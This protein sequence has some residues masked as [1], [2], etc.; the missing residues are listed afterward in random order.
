MLH[1]TLKPFPKDFLWGAS[2]SASQVEGAALEH[3]KGPSVQDV[4]EPPAGTSGFEVAADQYHRYAEDVALMAEMGFRTYRF[5]ISW[6]RLCPKAPA[7]STRRAS[8][9]TP[10]LSTSASS[11]A[12]SPW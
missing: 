8:P 2:T 9:T 5:S 12:S 10:P 6:A 3:G 4:K 11:T 7:A 1:K